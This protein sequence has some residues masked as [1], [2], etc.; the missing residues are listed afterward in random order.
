MKTTRSTIEQSQGRPQHIAMG[1]TKGGHEQN[2]VDVCILAPETPMS[3]FALGQAADELLSRIERDPRAPHYTE[4]AFRRKVDTSNRRATSLPLP[5]CGKEWLEI[6]RE[7][8]GEVIELANLT[9]RQA[10]VLEMRFAG[11][12]FE[13]IGAEGGHSKQGAQNI[14]F[15][16]AKK[17]VRAWMEYPYRGLSQVYREET[18]RGARGGH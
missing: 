11:F 6:L 13:Q 4:L 3:R 2:I 1:E 18:R 7:E 15:Q 10:E 8:W 17:L 14:F 5:S 9:E 16:G 12:T